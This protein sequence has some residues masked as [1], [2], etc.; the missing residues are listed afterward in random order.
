MSIRPTL[1]NYDDWYTNNLLPQFYV[2]GNLEGDQAH[3][4]IYQREY[5]SYSDFRA[6]VGRAPTQDELTGA[7]HILTNTADQNA[8]FS[9]LTN[10]KASVSNGPVGSTT[11]VSGTLA[12]T[13]STP[14]GTTTSFASQYT[15]PV[16]SI[17]Q[18]APAAQPTNYTIPLLLA[19]LF[20]LYFLMKK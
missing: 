12:P 10:L 20:G 17:Q 4:D 6:V 9:Y 15:S 5:T 7:Y 18:A 1:T 13:T 19:G 14:G 8:L 16:L 11:D 2:G 3:I